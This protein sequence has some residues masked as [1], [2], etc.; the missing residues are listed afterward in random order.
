MFSEIRTHGQHV[1]RRD[2][3]TNYCATQAARRPV[4]LSPPPVTLR[5]T[6]LSSRAAREL[7]ASPRQQQ[8]FGCVAWSH[9]SSAA[10]KRASVSEAGYFFAALIFAQRAFWA[11]TILA[12]PAALILCFCFF[13]A[14]TTAGAFAPPKSWLNSASNE[15]ICSLSSAA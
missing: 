15:A 8:E 6:A 3:G 5:K 2:Q 12:F 1:A 4:S 14:T 10:C 11:A 7:A 9:H 13:A